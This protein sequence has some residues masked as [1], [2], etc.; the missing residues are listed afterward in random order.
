[1][2][3]LLLMFLATLSLATFAGDKTSYEGKS[4]IIVE[5]HTVLD[6]P[7]AKVGSIR[8]ED[9]LYLST[10]KGKA[11]LVYKSWGEGKIKGL[12]EVA[13]VGA[14]NQP[15]RIDFIGID[16]GMGT[17]KLYRDEASIL[18]DASYGELSEYNSK[19]E[20]KFNDDINLTGMDSKHQKY[21]LITIY[22]NNSFGFKGKRK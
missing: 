6:M 17:F 5:V 1:M 18:K 13:E 4:N 12:I 3:N 14:C 11:G 10:R 9:Y 20:V 21:C 7:R 22:A 2:K 16:T 15:K 8:R 19:V